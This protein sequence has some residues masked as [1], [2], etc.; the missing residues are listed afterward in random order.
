LTSTSTSTWTSTCCVV[1]PHALPCPAEGFHAEA[2]SLQSPRLNVDGDDAPRLVA[3]RLAARLFMGDA[4][5][6]IRQAE[7]AVRESGRLVVLAPIGRV[8]DDAWSAILERL[9][10]ARA[11]AGKPPATL[12]WTGAEPFLAAHGEAAGRIAASPGFVDAALP[13]ANRGG[14]GVTQAARRHGA[15][16]GIALLADAG[17]PRLAISLGTA[18]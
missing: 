10:A 11:A 13:A 14:H 7:A 18:A 15:R 6:R 8:E 5:A 1:L 3:H 16:F 17:S 2:M 4:D 12:A 9:M